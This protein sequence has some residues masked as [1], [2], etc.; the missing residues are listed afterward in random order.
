MVTQHEPA[1][2]DAPR[3]RLVVSTALSAPVVAMAMVGP[4]QFTHWQWIS[5]TL[6]APVIGWAAFPFHRAAWANLRQGT[7]TMDTLVSLGTLAAFGW[8]LYALLFGTAGRPGLSHP[9]ELTVRRMSGDGDLYLGVAAGITT[10]ALAGRYFEAESRRMTGTGRWVP[11]D[12][13]DRISAVLVPSVLALAA[14]TLTFW[15]GTGASVTMACTAAVAVLIVACPCALAAAAPAALL[16]GIERGVRLGQVS[17]V[18]VHPAE[19]RGDTRI[20]L[21]ERI[22]RTVKVNLFLALACNVAALPL[23][24]AGLLSPALAGAAMVLSAVSVAS[25]TLRL[26][27][28]R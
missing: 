19:S 2:T 15:L 1:S 23:A 17:L 18:D 5:L 4:H 3:Q 12:T 28:F 11:P 7:A 27:T 26:R 20:R 21:L 16:T 9:F 13:A 10:C 14:G 6:A 22:A 25:N 8:S 24:A